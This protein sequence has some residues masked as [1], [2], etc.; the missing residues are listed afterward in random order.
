MNERY[1]LQQLSRSLT[2]ITDFL[3]LKVIKGKARTNSEQVSVTE[4]KPGLFINS[5][6]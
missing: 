1:E 4:F 2:Q 3:C 5:A 6:P